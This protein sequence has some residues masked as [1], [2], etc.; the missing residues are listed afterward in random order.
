MR[1]G[2]RRATILVL[3]L[4]LAAP[5]LAGCSLAKLKDALYAGGKLTYDTLKSANDSRETE[6]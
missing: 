4:T 1:T 2:L 3:A 5:S 6:H